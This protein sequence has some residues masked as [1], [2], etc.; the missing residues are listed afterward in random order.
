MKGRTLT[1][2]ESL[3]GSACWIVPHW[4]IRK[5]GSVSLSE[6]QVIRTINSEGGV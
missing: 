3:L 5:R 4:R 2:A 6:A 1:R